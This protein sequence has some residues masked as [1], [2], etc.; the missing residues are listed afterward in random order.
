M[1]YCEFGNLYDLLK[2]QKKFDPD[3]SLNFISQILNGYFTLDKLNIIHRDLK[4][5]NIFVTKNQT[6]Q[7]ILK[8]GDFGIGKQSEQTQSKIGTVCYM[9]P[10]MVEKIDNKYNK[11]IDIW[12]LGCILLELLTG[13]KFFNGIDKNDVIKNILNFDFKKIQENFKSFLMVF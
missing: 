9:A 4:P 5:Q 8:L 10:E 6:N 2:T 11:K 7:I 13:K 1:E 12:A 3:I